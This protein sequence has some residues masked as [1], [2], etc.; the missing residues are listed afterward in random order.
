MAP[1]NP[2]QAQPAAFERTVFSH[3]FNSVM[4]AGGIKSAR[5]R[6]GRGDVALVKCKDVNE[7]FTRQ[8][9]HEPEA[10]NVVKV[11]LFYDEFPAK[12]LLLYQ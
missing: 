7:Q 1:K 9:C 8:L 12:A 2:F 3:C 4:R 11:G 6:E 10:L 5:R